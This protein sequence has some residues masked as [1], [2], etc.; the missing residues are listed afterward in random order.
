MAGEP[1]TRGFD[2]FREIYD[3]GVL[4]RVTGDILAISPPL[5]AEKGHVDEIFGTVGEVLKKAA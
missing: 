3:K 2:T 5:I 4:T 1:G